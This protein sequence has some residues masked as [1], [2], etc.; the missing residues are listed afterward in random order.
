MVSS[1]GDGRGQEALQSV[2]SCDEVS[3]DEL[4]NCTW[5]TEFDDFETFESHSQEIANNLAET[6]VPIGVERFDVMCVKAP[7]LGFLALLI[8]LLVVLIMPYCISLTR[9]VKLVR[10]KP[11]PTQF[12]TINTSSQVPAEKLNSALVSRSP[13]TAVQPEKLDGSGKYKWNIKASDHYI[14]SGAGGSRP[15]RVDWAGQAPPSAPKEYR[16]DD[17]MENIPLR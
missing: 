7:W 17:N 13:S 4:E 6:V 15:L 10:L 11:T 1:G 5:Y 12:E 8:P 3:S 9:R 2:S 14:W 16:D